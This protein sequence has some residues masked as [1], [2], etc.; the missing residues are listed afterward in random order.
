MSDLKR[1]IN[2]LVGSRRLVIQEG[3]MIGN[4]NTKVTWRD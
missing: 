2:L 3:V 1:V 4:E